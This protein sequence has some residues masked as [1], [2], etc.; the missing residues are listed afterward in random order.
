MKRDNWLSLLQ[1]VFSIECNHRF[2]TKDVMNTKQ[3]PLCVKCKRSLSFLSFGGIMHITDGEK[4][5]IRRAIRAADAFGLGRMSLARA[6]IEDYGYTWTDEHT[7]FLQ[8][9]DAYSGKE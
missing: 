8:Q 9:T 7:N 1:G 5:T 4:D 3:D 6:E 2:N